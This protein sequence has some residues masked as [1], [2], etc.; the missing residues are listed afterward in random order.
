M[1]YHD[2]CRRRAF[3]E[4]A[5]VPGVFTLGEDNAQTR[6]ELGVL[7]EQAEDLRRRAET[8]QARLTGDKRAGGLRQTREAH[9]EDV[10]DILWKTEQRSSTRAG[11]RSPAPA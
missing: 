9:G 8:E 11:P 6:E 1:V 3:Y 5:A 7:K 2:D 10:R 4:N